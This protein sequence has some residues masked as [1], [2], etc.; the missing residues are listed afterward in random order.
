MDKDPLYFA[1]DKPSI[2][3]ACTLPVRAGGEL[4]NFQHVAS[5]R[6]QGW[7]VFAWVDEGVPLEW[8][9]RPFPVPLLQ[10]GPH[11][12]WL[13]HDILV[14]PEVVS[15]SSWQSMRSW[16]C[17]LVMHNQNPFYTFKGLPN[18][19]ELNDFPLAGGLCCSG[20]TRNTLQGWGATIDWQVVQPIVL[21][22]FERAWT[23][24]RGLAGK[25]MQIA[26][27]PRKRMAEAVQLKQ[28]FDALCPQWQ[29]VP[30]VVIDAMSRPQVAQVMAESL[31]FV[32][33]S[34]DEGLG[35]PPL[36]AMAAG[37]LVAGFTGQGGQEYA[38]PTN[39]EWVSEGQLPELALAIAR[40]LSMDSQQQ[41]ARVQAGQV[42]A[43][44]FSEANFE[45]QLSQA[46]HHLLGNSAAAYKLNASE[47]HTRGGL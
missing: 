33:L 29:H 3:Y 4:V 45:A 22:H 35:L 18:I 8:P 9:S 6:Q 20:F 17:Q 11:H 39:G 5:L 23:S 30:W 31:L 13:T 47:A 38:T 36:E 28:W 42:T 2:Y 32:S 16:G 7:R 44:L 24:V 26:Y 14:L 12:Q 43:G 21:P 15:N 37:C 19:R 27:M 1:E 25:K 40:L 10:G 34:K 46:W 41:A